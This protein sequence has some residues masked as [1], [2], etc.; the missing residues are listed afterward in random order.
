MR[1][2][3]IRAAMDIVRGAM[4][5]TERL[6]EAIRV[7]EPTVEEVEKKYLP[8]F[9]TTWELY[10]WAKDLLDHENDGCSPHKAARL[11][12]ACA[13]RGNTVAKYRLGKMYLKGD[14][15]EKDT[16]AALRWLS[17]AAEGGNEYAEYLLGKTYLKG[18]DVER[19]TIKAESYLRRAAGRGNR[20]AA[21]T[22]GKAL[23]DG[24]VLEQDI[25]ESIRY[26]KQAADA[27]FKP[28]QYVLGKMYYKGEGAE[29][30][31]KKALEYLAKAADEYPNAAYL[32]GKICLIVCKAA[33]KTSRCE[34][35]AGSPG[36]SQQLLF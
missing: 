13:K 1:N 7:A 18:E 4:P 8:N 27:G 26:L 28:V 14:E 24:D 32:A 19:D 3:V 30:D 12:E 35:L 25:S 6:N 16:A 5:D 22:L 20:H 34:L 21:Y 31:L 2:A 9:K 23:S 11:L 17:R 29:Q 33:V 10:F 15:I 36:K